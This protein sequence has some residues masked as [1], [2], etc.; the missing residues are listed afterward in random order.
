LPRECSW[1]VLGDKRGLYSKEGVTVS[2]HVLDTQVFQIKP[3]K[4]ILSALGEDNWKEVCLVLDPNGSKPKSDPDPIR[5]RIRR[6]FDVDT[7]TKLNISEKRRDLLLSFHLKS[8]VRVRL[9]LVG[10]L[11]LF[12]IE[13]CV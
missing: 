1:Y 13:C 5:S 11:F 10:L 12:H 2:T 9:L 6:I 3:I 7:K 4:D 8:C